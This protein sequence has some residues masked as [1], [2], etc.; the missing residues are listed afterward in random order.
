MKYEPIHTAKYSVRYVEG[1][2]VG[3]Q[4]DVWDAIC[5]A[6][7]KAVDVL[8]VPGHLFV[9][10]VGADTFSCDPEDCGRRRTARPSRATTFAAPCAFFC[11]P[12]LNGE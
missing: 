9:T 4:Q 2:P 1:G 11:Y 6:V 12:S 7:D 10:V 3:T 8:N 5:Y